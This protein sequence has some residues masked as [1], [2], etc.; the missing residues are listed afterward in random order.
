MRADAEVA[1]SMPASELEALF[2]AEGAFGSARS[3]IERVLADW[4][5]ARGIS[6]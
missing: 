5:T 3:M 2:K 6:P 1:R 4:A